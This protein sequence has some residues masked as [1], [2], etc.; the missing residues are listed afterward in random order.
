MGKLLSDYIV[1]F[2]FVKQRNITNNSFYYLRV[3]CFL[4]EQ[5]KHFGDLFSQNSRWV[6]NELAET[7]DIF[8][9]NEIDGF[10]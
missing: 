9:L 1:D 4:S 6:N 10:F 7:L 3:V 8:V 5:G 2:L